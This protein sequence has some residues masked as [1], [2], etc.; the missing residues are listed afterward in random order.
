MTLDG[1]AKNDIDCIEHIKKLASVLRKYPQ[2]TDI[3]AITG[4]KVP[5]VKFFLRHAKVEADISMYNEVAL[6][7]TKLLATYVHID[8]R[9]QILGCTLKIFVKVCVYMLTRL[10]K[11]HIYTQAFHICLQGPVVPR[12]VSANPGLKVNLLF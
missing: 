7:N 2:C 1:K 5:I 10:V 4:A 11:A 6:M 12:W 9:V 3:V 8:Q